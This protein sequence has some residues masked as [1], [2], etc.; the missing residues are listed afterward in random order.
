MHNKYPFEIIL[1]E[2][3]KDTPELTLVLDL[4][5]TLVHSSFTRISE[6]DIEIHVPSE[7]DDTYVLYRFNLDLCEC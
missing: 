2:K 4:D 6:S 5:E 1:P 7:S 3:S